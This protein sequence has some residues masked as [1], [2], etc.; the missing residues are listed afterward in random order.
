ML[1]VHHPWL[2]R[3]AR[4]PTEA[5][6]AVEIAVGDELEAHR[7]Q[8]VVNLPL[9]LQFHLV[10]VLLGQGV[11]HLPE[12]I[13]V[14]FCGIDMAADQFRGERLAQ[15]DAARNGAVGVV[16]VIDGNVDAL[17]HLFLRLGTSR[18]L[19]PRRCQPP[20]PN[21]Q[22]PICKGSRSREPGECRGDASLALG[23]GC[24]ELGVGS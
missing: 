1:P 24:W 3:E 9:A 2:E 20:T 21:S 5:R 16:R 11:L 7:D 6:H 12:A 13:I 8:A 22:L 14:Q 18:L 17:V 15:R 10:D 19:N 4:R 23:I